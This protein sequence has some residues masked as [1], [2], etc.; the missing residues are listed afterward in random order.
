MTRGL[1]ATR[2]RTAARPAQAPAMREAALRRVLRAMEKPERVLIATHQHPDGDCIGVALALHHH[3]KRLGRQVRGFNQDP[4]PEMFRFLPGWRAISNRITR[5][6]PQAIILLDSGS[7]SRLGD[8]P[9]AWEQLPVVN[10]D[11]HR[12]NTFRGPHSFVDGAASSVGELMYDLL[13]A[14]RRPLT[15]AIARCLYI[16]ILTDTGSFRQANTTPHALEVAA[17]LL[18]AGRMVPS[19]V[20]DHVYNR[21]E[22]RQLRLLREMLGTIRIAAGGKLAWAQLTRR[23]FAAAGARDEDT[24]GLIGYLRTINGVRVAAVLRETASGRV[25]LNL[26]S[27]TDISVLPVVKRFGGGGHPNAAGCTVSMTMAEAQRRML[28]HL[29]RLAR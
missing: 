10:L 9:P 15:P 11:H 3:L 22:L 21:V 28:P 6:K 5:F 7:W 13:R 23:M 18:R 29:R 1:P 4:V 2:R 12:D 26:R 17:E 16:A 24:E 20:A 14:G 8:Y 27:R 19:E 25:K